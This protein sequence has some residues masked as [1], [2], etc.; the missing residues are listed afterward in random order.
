MNVD[1]FVDTNILVYAHDRDAGEKHTRARALLEGFWETRQIPSVN[2]SVIIE[3]QEAPD[4]LCYANI[5]SLIGPDRCNL[6]QVD[7][8]AIASDDKT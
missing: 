5:H 4:R 3:S 7:G 8:D 1:I 6:C 2:D